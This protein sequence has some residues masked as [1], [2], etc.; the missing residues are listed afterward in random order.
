MRIS[1]GKGFAKPADV[2]LSILVPAFVTSELKT[3]FQIGFLL[4]IPFVIIDLVVA[5]V[6]MSMG[7]MMLSPVLISLPFKIM[8]FVLIDGW[9]LVM[10]TLAQSFFD[11]VSMTPEMVVT[12][13]RHALE[14]TLMLS[15]PLLL[16]ALAVGLIVGIFQAATSINEMT[17]SFIPK[18]L[19]MAAVLAITGPVDDPHAGRIFARAH[20][21]HPG[22]GRMSIALS[23]GQLEGWVAQ[24]FFPFARIGA[25]LMVA[26]VFGARFVPPRTRIILAVAITALVAPMI[27]TP[28]IAPFSPQGFVVVFQQLLIG[29][30]LGF[31]LQIVFDALGLAGQLL[32]NSMGLSFA[33]N[34]DPLRGSSTPALGQ[35]YIILATLTFLALDGHAALDR[36]T[37]RRP[38]RAARRYDRA[39]AGRAVGAHHLV[40]PVVRG[41]DCRGAARHHR[42]A[43]RES[44][45]RRREPRGAVA[46]PVRGRLSGFAGRRVCWSCSPA[47]GPCRRVS[48]RC[49]RR[50]SISCARCTEGRESWRSPA[51]NAQ[52]KLHRSASRRRARKARFRAPSSCRWR[53]CASRPPRLSTRWG[54][55]RPASSPTSC[56]AC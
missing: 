44:R 28:A 40:R 1:G 37:G 21:K 31:A 43:H 6:L 54:A 36:T 19:A 32:A 34:V 30:A 2:P 42:A 13:G 39:R 49:W 14:V 16:T 41:R 26:P 7:M 25:C 38:V 47:S 27:P 12:I 50:D 51:Q 5:S 46:E 9:A 8:L 20:R 53:R 17:L 10:G 3:A 15:A 18:L 45:L 4:F 35:L 22:D 48:P 56:A 33:M 23:I 55:A 11:R 24:G 52:N 29:V